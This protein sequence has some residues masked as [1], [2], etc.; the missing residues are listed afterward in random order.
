MP[1]VIKS[2][3]RASFSISFALSPLRCHWTSSFSW[4]QA[5]SVEKLSFPA[6][7]SSFV[8][9]G[10]PA[11]DRFYTPVRDWP[12]CRKGDVQAVNGSSKTSDKG[13]AS[14]QPK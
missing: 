3:R 6:G 13:V 5:R 9:T 12:G 4:G 2:K 8:V 7:R 1:R 11:T 10:P 14:A